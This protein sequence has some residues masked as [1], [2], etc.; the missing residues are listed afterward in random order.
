MDWDLWTYP[1]PE[2]IG[3]PSLVFDGGRVLL[4][5]SEVWKA[6][7]LISKTPQVLRHCVAQVAA[8]NQ[9]DVSKAFAICTAG[10][11][12][13]GVLKS[14]SKTLSKKGRGKAGARGKEP[15]SKQK[16]ID[17]EQLVAAARKG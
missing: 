14:G 15:D 6:G 13:A 5:L 16:D 9:G 10:L 2:V 3:E 12:K 8:K 7:K 1:L 11:Q 17:Y 4:P